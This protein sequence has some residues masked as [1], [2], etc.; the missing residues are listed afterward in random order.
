MKTLFAFG[1]RDVLM[2]GSRKQTIQKRPAIVRIGDRRVSRFAQRQTLFGVG[3]V[4]LETQIAQT[5][6][7][8]GIVGAFMHAAAVIGIAFIH[9]VTTG[10]I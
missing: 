6:V 9:V 8:T 3:G 2:F 7:R 10:A 5:F 4:N 1:Q